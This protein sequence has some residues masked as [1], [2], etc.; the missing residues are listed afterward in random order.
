MSFRIL[1]REIIVLRGKNTRALEKLKER[2]VP[3]FEG[4]AAATGCTVEIIW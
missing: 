3:I 4:A 2:V 1:R